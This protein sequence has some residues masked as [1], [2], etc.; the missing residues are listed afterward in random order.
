MGKAH[1]TLYLHSQLQSFTES[2]NFPETYPNAFK[3][4]KNKYAYRRASNGWIETDLDDENQD[5]L[6]KPEKQTISVN[7]FLEGIE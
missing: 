2:H 4:K 6:H 3:E 5:I 1:F 7:I